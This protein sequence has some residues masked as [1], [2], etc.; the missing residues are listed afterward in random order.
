MAVCS[1]KVGEVHMMITKKCI[2][3]ILNVIANDESFDICYNSKNNEYAFP[4]TEL[5]HL[6]KKLNDYSFER[7]AYCCYLLSCD[8]YIELQLSTS[9]RGF[10]ISRICGITLKGYELLEKLNNEL[11]EDCRKRQA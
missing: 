10:S 9:L 7:L 2:F 5:Y 11:K 3:D 1:G 4:D 8:G 6:H